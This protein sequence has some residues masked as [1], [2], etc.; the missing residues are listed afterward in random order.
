[1]V[2]W[3]Y[4]WSTI[5]EKTIPTGHS[6]RHRDRPA[7]HTSNLAET[8]GRAQILGPDPLT[9]RAWRGQRTSLA[10]LLQPLGE[11]DRRGISKMGLD[12]ECDSTLGALTFRENTGMLV[13]RR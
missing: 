8:E 9:W 12:L 3:Y 5:T 1:V 10:L 4:C 6:A 11:F 7:N 2:L 13:D